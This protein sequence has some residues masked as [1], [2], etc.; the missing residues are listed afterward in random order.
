MDNLI[1]IDLSQ[2]YI[3]TL[4]SGVFGNNYLNE[5]NMSGN[6]LKELEEETFVNLPILE[7][8]DLSHNNLIGIK[9]GAFDAIPRLKKLYMTHNRLSS[10]KGDYFANMGNDTDLH[11][12]ES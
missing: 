6:L 5:V 4:E 1:S 12:L 7:S 9:N 10:Y 11:T 2:N 8:L 3:R